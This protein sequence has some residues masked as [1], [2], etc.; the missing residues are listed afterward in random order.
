MWVL[1]LLRHAV[2]NLLDERT[3]TSRLGD[4]LIAA[5]V[6]EADSYSNARGAA[7]LYGYREKASFLRPLGS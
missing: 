3:C 6:I 1:S 2:L 7:S 5:P 4:A